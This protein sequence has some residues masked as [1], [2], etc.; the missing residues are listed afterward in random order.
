M[1]ASLSQLSTGGCANV[2]QPWVDAS[3]LL[4]SDLENSSDIKQFTT[5][6]VVILSIWV[7]ISEKR[8]F[9]NVFSF[10]LALGEPASQ[11][12]GR[13]LC[14]RYLQ[15]SATHTKTI[16]MDKKHKK[17][18]LL[19]WIVPSIFLIY[20]YFLTAIYLLI[21]SVILMFIS[22]DIHQKFLSKLGSAFDLWTLAWACPPWQS[23]YSPGRAPDTKSIIHTA[24]A[25]SQLISVQSGCNSASHTPGVCQRNISQRRAAALR[26][27]VTAIQYYYRNV[28][29]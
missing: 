19:G 7:R 23:H 25:W 12:K 28:V 3:F 21:F 14:G 8:R 16:Y 20:L 2:S 15:N 10:F 26:L 29:I 18:S 1:H 4:N 9:S 27:S 13:H 22:R 11:M 5:R 6:S 24:Q 17:F